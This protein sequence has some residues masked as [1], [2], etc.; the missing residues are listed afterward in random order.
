[1]EMDSQMKLMEIV[2]ISNQMMIIISILKRTPILIIIIE[3]QRKL[4]QIIL[5]GH[6]W[7]IIGG[8]TSGHTA[9]KRQQSHQ[10]PLLFLARQPRFLQ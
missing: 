3:D 2:P 9:P 8:S 1:M 4:L 5:I 7:S 6:K 10:H